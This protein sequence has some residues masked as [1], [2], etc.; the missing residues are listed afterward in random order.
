MR[1]ALDAMGGDHAPEATIA[2]AAQA[3]ADIV[4]IDLVL[5]GHQER[6][7]PL[8]KE[9]RLLRH[10]RVELIHADEVVAMDELSTAAI[11]GKKNASITVA[12]ELVKEGRAD[13]LVSAGHT[14]AAVAAT[15][16]KLRPLPGVERPAI[17]TIMPAV[18][19]HFI[20]IDAGATIDCK[21]IHLAQFAV[22]GEV[23]AK[24]A[25]GIHNPSIGLLSVGGEDVKG[26]ELT[27]ETF[28]R[29]SE[30]P[31][32]F[33]GNVEGNDI[34][35]RST[36]VIV[37]DGFVGNVLLKAS[38]SMAV[39][40]MHWLKEALS[41]NPFRITGAM[42]AKNAF[43][44]LKEIGDADEIG[45]APLL[46]LNGIC[47]I[48]HGSSSPKAIRNAIRVAQNSVKHHV[49]EQIR[50]RIAAC[51]IAIPA[52]KPTASKAATP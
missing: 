15:T 9:H 31:I 6:L 23:Y 5:V 11:R 35:I 42:L 13:A 26:N 14:G 44:E 2:G 50:E 34:F 10:P 28:K 43:R 38:E 30:M 24:L 47:I 51:G 1:I 16:V 12:A 40:V 7:K 49:G 48:G 3:L 21:P 45:G 20:L 52:P 33:A 36:D 37:C 46:G 32:N 22:M 4:G 18:G 8:L 19:G 29:L 25:L 27:K 39:A 41:K 17:A